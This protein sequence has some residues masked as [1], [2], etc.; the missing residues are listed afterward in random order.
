[1]VSDGAMQGG[2]AVS[3]LLLLIPVGLWAGW[4]LLVALDLSSGAYVPDA[5]YEARSRREE[6]FED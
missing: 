6:D 3:A 2:V 5:E 1:L 4:R